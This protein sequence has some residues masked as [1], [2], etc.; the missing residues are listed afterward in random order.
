MWSNM[1]K[2]AAFAKQI[3]VLGNI[4]LPFTF[5]SEKVKQQFCVSDH[6]KTPIILG[7]DFICKYNIYLKIGEQKCEING[8][9][10]SLTDHDE[11]TS[12][13]RLTDS[14]EIPP[15]H[16]FSCKGKYHKQFNIEDKNS[17][18][19]ITQIDTGFMAE[20]PG[21]EL[22]EADRMGMAIVT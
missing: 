5:G 15:Q 18:L 14:I 7:R 19:M 4:K 10:V 21:E 3:N 8:K 6:I 22:Q 13:I 1:G 2:I 17:D 12:F 9:E 11:I 16:V 20:E